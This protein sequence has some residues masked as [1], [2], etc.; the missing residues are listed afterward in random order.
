MEWRCQCSL[1]LTCREDQARGRARTPPGQAHGAGES[2][3]VLPALVPYLHSDAEVHHGDAGVTV[4]AHV[5]HGVAAVRG[6][7]L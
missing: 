5:H 1:C 2:C 3:T 6:L 7:A 4:P